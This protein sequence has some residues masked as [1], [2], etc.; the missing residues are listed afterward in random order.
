MSLQLDPGTGLG[1]KKVTFLLEKANRCGSLK[2]RDEVTMT[3]GKL[4]GGAN[5]PAERGGTASLCRCMILELMETDDVFF[6][7]CYSGKLCP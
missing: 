6:L 7:S 4:C 5:G 2:G 1:E 3:E